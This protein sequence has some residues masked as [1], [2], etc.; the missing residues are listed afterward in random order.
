[1]LES[2]DRGYIVLDDRHNRSMSSFL[3]DVAA[4]NGKFK[5]LHLSGKNNTPPFT[6]WHPGIEVGCLKVLLQ[7]LHNGGIYSVFDCCKVSTAASVLATQTRRADLSGP[8]LQSQ[9]TNVGKYLADRLMDMYSE[10]FVEKRDFAHVQGNNFVGSV[11]SDDVLILP[12]MRGGEPMSR[13]IY[14]RFPNAKLV[15][16][17]HDEQTESCNR[18]SKALAKVS[19]VIIVDSVVN[20]GKS[21]RD[22]IHHIHKLMTNCAE[23]GTNCKSTTSLLP[24]RIFVVT[25]VMQMEASRRLPV[26]YPLIRFVA[27]RISDN[28]YKGRG[29]TDTGNRLFGT[30]SK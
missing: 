15:H 27:L 11:V 20:E 7:E 19:N 26:D 23:N 28:K 25:A 3:S 14:E 21:V 1:M 18:L 24:P 22:V 10:Y 6:G 5:Q 29:G 8:D 17:Y 4:K 12:L 13:G 16:Y 9:H 2:S 30:F